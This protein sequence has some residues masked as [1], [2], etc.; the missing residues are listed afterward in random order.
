MVGV[1][2][3]QNLTKILTNK[4]IQTMETMV[5]VNGMTAHRANVIFAQTGYIYG[6]ISMYYPFEEYIGIYL[7]GCVSAEILLPSRHSE[8]QA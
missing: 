4:K 6:F 8:R 7:K 5:I 1:N 2:P 3:E